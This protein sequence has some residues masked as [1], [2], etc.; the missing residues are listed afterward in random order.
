MNTILN[1][2]LLFDLTLLENA[3]GI[4]SPEYAFII[5]FFGELVVFY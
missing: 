3:R 1:Q 2:L 4:V 5:Q